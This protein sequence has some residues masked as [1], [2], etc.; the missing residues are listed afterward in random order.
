MK[1]YE[2]YV[3]DNDSERSIGFYESM[4]GATFAMSKHIEQGEDVHVRVADVED[5]EAD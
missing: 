3:K 2:V 5:T 1:A 4:L